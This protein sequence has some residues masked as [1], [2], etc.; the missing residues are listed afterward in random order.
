MTLSSVK[1]YGKPDLRCTICQCTLGV[2]ENQ[3]LS[4][5]LEKKMLM[6]TE[7]PGLVELYSDIR[8]SSSSNKAVQKSK[9]KTCKLAPENICDDTLKN[10][11][12]F[13]RHGVK[14]Y[15]NIGK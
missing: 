10:L 1:F 8:R 4:R 5:M 3:G 11:R 14:V 9:N 6:T 7:M 2:N 13:E 12:L 15:V